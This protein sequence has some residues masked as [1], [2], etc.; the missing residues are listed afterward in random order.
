MKLTEI[1]NRGSDYEVVK[2]IPSQFKAQKKFGDRTI[3]LV[4]NYLEDE[5]IWEVA[6][7]NLDGDNTKLT[8][9]HRAIEVLNFVSAAMKEFVQLYAPE[10]F[11]WSVENDAEG[12]KREK[13][14]DRMFSRNFPEYKKEI[15]FNGSSSKSRYHA[16]TLKE[17]DGAHAVANLI[18]PEDARTHFILISK[19]ASDIVKKAFTPE[20]IKYVLRQG[21]D[22]EG[23]TL[24][25]TSDEGDIFQDLPK[26]IYTKSEIDVVY[27][28]T[29]KNHDVRIFPSTEQG[30]EHASTVFLTKIS[31]ALNM[32]KN[33]TRWGKD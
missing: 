17:N 23:L 7:F 27:Y 5:E 14:Y 26:L 21:N 19:Q 30:I 29:D 2:N 16:Y 13:I 12:D 3:R 1:F 6:F 18:D 32:L 11:M 22:D 31:D 28:T 33:D 9:D 20:P 15:P 8:N 24:L 10:K 25:L 4:C